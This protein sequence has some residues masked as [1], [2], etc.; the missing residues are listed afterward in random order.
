PKFSGLSSA[1]RTESLS[2]ARASTSS[3]FGRLTRSSYLKNWM[4]LFGHQRVD[5]DDGLTI[6]RSQRLLALSVPL[7]RFTSLIR[8]GSA[9][10]VRR[11]RFYEMPH[12][13][14]S[15]GITGLTNARLLQAGG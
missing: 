5:Y 13:T 3:C 14:C 7:S 4:A 6:R 12:C 10:F 2:L 11:H 8:R 15:R 9:F 1:H